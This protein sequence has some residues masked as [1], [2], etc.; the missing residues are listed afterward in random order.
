LGSAGTLFVVATPIGNLG[1]ITFRAIEVLRGVD[2][3]AAEG[4]NRT[5][6]LCRHYGINTT[7]RSFNQHN[8]KR[9]VPELLAFL[10]SGKQVALVTNAGTPCISDPGAFLVDKAL[11]EA[12]KVVPIPGV[13]AVT[14]ALSVSGLGAERFVFMGFL[15]AKQGQR[16]RELS[17]WGNTG[18]PIVIYEAPHRIL[19]TLEDIKE[20]LGDPVV[21][22]AKELTKLHEEI[23]RARAS[24][25][26][27]SLR[28]EQIRGE[29]V[30]ILGP[31][32][33]PST[34]DKD[35]MVKM[36]GRML[37][38]GEGSVRDIAR[39]ISE[40]TGW[41]FRRVYKIALEIQRAKG[42]G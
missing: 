1:D 15:P 38:G 34:G 8:Q 24:D 20:L 17:K 37:D 32:G 4:V 13:S 33:G 14:S 42:T 31:Q 23:N 5:R 9:R 2:L 40:R 12:I 30:L 6:A 11:A 27:E 3:I 22:L 36:I 21:V 39:H 25:L 26:L 18:I 10:K 19:H 28:D 7:V 16:R 35:E 41:P 29:F